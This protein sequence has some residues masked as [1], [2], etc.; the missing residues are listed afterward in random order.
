VEKAV[1]LE[2]INPAWATKKGR[3]PTPGSAENSR[4]NWSKVYYINGVKMGKRVGKPV[5]KFT[6]D[7]INGYLSL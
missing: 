1:N 7:N 5:R 6:R 3:H 2:K 4:R